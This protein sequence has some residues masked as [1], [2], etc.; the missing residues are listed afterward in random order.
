MIHLPGLLLGFLLGPLILGIVLGLV[1]LVMNYKI[2]MQDFIGGF[3]LFFGLVIIG[4][5]YVVA[6]VKI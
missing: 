6:F 1:T 3:G 4:M 2:P 5:G